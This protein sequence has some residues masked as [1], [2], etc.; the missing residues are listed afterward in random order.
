M[1]PCSLRPITYRSHPQK[2]IGVRS[3]SNAIGLAYAFLW[4]V[5]ACSFFVVPKYAERRRKTPGSERTKKNIVTIIDGRGT[6]NLSMIPSALLD[7]PMTL[8]TVAPAYMLITNTAYLL[9]RSHIRDMTKR[10]LLQ[11]RTTR[12]EGVSLR[13]HMT[14]ILVWQLFVV[15]IFPLL[16]PTSRIFGYVSFYYFYPNASGM[17]IVFEPLSVQ[18]LSMSKRTK[19]QI[20]CDWHKFSVNV[21][22]VGRDGYR[23]PP[24]VERNLPHLDIPARG[25]KHWPWRRKLGV[26][27]AKK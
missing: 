21:G 19:S 18:S 7:A 14:N 24:K 4:L 23:H 16:E 8:S 11:I 26:E 5:P 25:W 2:M 1:S 22:R 9:R 20:R 15:F 12:E 13:L 3:K 17:G 27:P 6:T 10:K